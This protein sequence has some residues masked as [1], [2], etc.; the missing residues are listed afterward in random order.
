MKRLIMAGA[1]VVSLA[2]TAW[3]FVPIAAL[4]EADTL[5]ARH[6]NGCANI[7]SD[8]ITGMSDGRE[9]EWRKFCGTADP[10]TCAATL[11]FIAQQ[12]PGANPGFE[13][14][15]PQPGNV[16]RDREAKDP[17]AL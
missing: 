3:G 15:G 4:K 2:G 11:Q 14:R 10:D 1:L 5:T 7:A 9:E 6:E 12:R 13:C 16:S 8:V 17:A